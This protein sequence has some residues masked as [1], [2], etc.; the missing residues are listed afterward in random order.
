MI[1]RLNAGVGRGVVVTCR[2]PASALVLFCF[3]VAG[4]ASIGPG[5]VPR[6]R[7]DYITAVADSWKEQTLLNVVRMRY[8]DA[9]S[10]VDV[11][12][13][14]SAYTFQ[15]QV[16]AG[17][18]IN[19]GAPSS[20]P[21]G[22]A[23]FGGVSSY[24]DRPTITYTP[25][26][27]DR[28]SRSLLRPIPPSAIFELIQ[29]GFPADVMLLITTRGIN[30]LSNRNSLGG[31]AREADPD[32]YEVLAV[33]RR[34]QLSG[35]VSLRVQRKDGEDLGLV[36][37]SSGRTQQS[38]RDLQF[39]L[40][41]LKVKPGKGGEITLA[42][43]ILPRSENE[44]AVLSRSMVGVLLEVANGIMVPDADVA[45]GRAMPSGRR[46]EAPDPRDRP[47]VQVHSSASQ[48]AGAYAAVHYRDSWYWIP[49]NDFAS[50]RVFTFLM[51]FFSLAETG[52]TTQPPLVT[53]PAN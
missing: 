3:A 53:I 40:E 23:T 15:G 31:E 12:S 34:L 30:G 9:P 21:S 35:E 24:S 2:K 10:F 38:T 51:L 25:L 22:V 50:K 28:F 41:K 43:G 27:G 4:C 13:V 7:S 47:L 36:I 20:V 49:D 39:L 6:D 19:S 5:T 37:I 17:G 32:F 48:P 14:I 46:Q 1:P 29:A 8:G 26:V 16:S 52:V 45:A 42:F 44:I 11:S 18:Q 33:L